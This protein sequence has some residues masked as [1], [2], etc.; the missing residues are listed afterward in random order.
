MAEHTA[1]N[2]FVVGSIP[3]KL[4]LIPQ[5]DFLCFGVLVWSLIIILSILYFFLIT[6]VLPSFSEVKKFRAK[7]AVED[8]LICQTV[9][10]NK[11]IYYNLKSKKFLN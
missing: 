9:V 5:F 2:G 7:K 8:N 3:A 6:N 1:H 11:N 10:I 4:T